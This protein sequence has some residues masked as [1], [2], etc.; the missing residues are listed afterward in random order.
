MLRGVRLGDVGNGYIKPF[1]FHISS[2]LTSSRHFSFF[3]KSKMYTG[4]SSQLSSSLSQNTHG[5]NHGWS[6]I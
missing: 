1:L 5:M 4:M 2:F 3:Q 6:I